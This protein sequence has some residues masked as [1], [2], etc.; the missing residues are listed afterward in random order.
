MPLKIFTVS[1]IKDNQKGSL[2]YECK[3][4]EYRKR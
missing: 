4:R 2:G 1:V 3:C